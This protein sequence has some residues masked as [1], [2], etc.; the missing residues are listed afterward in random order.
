MS[1]SSEF[2]RCALSLCFWHVIVPKPPRCF[3]RHALASSG[4]NVIKPSEEIDCHQPPPPP[5]PPPPPEK[6]PP[7][8][9]LEDELLGGVGKEDVIVSV[10]EPAKPPIASV[11]DPGPDESP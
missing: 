4:E 5:P 7:E 6:P 3:G 1:R 9:K 2:M 8:E 10:I 11:K